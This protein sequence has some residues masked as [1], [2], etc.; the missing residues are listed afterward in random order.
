MLTLLRT[1]HYN[2][3]SQK[4]DSPTFLSFLITFFDNF[5][6]FMNLHSQ[7]SFLK[8]HYVNAENSKLYINM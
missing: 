7:F 6:L 3:L 2:K 5:V 4:S 8:M 1:Q